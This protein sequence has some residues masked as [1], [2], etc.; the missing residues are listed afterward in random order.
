MLSVML[1]TKFD[2]LGAKQASQLAVSGAK[3]KLV[4]GSGQDYLLSDE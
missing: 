3:K 4:F 1:L 2:K